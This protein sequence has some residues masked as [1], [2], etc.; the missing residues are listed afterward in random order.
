M[1]KLLTIL[2]APPRFYDAE[3][4]EL[5][6]WS[7]S[8]L[9]DWLGFYDILRDASN[10]PIGLRFWPFED[11]SKMLVSIPPSPQIRVEE[12]GAAL[13]LLFGVFDQ[14]SEERSG[15]QLFDESR[16]LTQP[17]NEVALLFGLSMLTSSDQLALEREITDSSP[18]T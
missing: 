1:K 13:C 16:L 4:C 7:D 14:W 17:N 3:T 9:G 12:G 2:G 15:D 5:T 11:A 8:G 6:K 18:P 10:R